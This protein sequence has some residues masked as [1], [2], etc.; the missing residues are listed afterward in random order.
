MSFKTPKF[1]Y[2]DLTTPP[3]MSEKILSVFSWIYRAL[4]KIHQLSKI[5]Y[6][7]EI[8]VLCLGNL[9][10]G[11]TG[12]TPTA[13]AIFDLIKKE[14]I[15]QSPYF[16]LRGYGG[17][18]VGPL[19]VDTQK[20]T[21]WD[22]GDE[23]LILAKK[24]PTIVAADRAGGAKLAQS[25]G[26]DFIIM[27]DGLQNPGIHKDIKIII[28][29]GEMGLGNQKLIP[30]GPIR[31]PLSEGLNSAHGFIMIGED[32]RDIKRWLPPSK[33]LIKAHIK[34]SDCNNVDLGAPYIAF[35]GLGYPQKFFNFLK[36]EAGLNIIKTI[37]FCDH[38]PYTEE[39]ILKLRTTADRLNCK[40]ITT[41]KDFLRIP[42]SV[43]QD[44]EIMH[45]DMVFD[46]PQLLAQLIKNTL[47]K[48]S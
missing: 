1:W 25:K 17:A 18:E 48:T 38:Y 20:H 9:V 27:D 42:A 29:N 3:P 12:K 24:A 22:V 16:L 21:A 36:H 4:Y 15:A 8:P 34:K 33:I 2:R 32:Q 35:A 41:E 5:P 44:I 47:S 23:A 39:D 26:A 11:G 28:I 10:A 30:A 14:S 7:A 37:E 46:E 40:L 19:F 45:I 43:H 6:K 13:L 31:Q